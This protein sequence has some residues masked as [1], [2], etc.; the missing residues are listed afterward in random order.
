MK[1]I[2]KL[3]SILLLTLVILSMTFPAA[4]SKITT[5][6]KAEI[7]EAVKVVTSI[8]GNFYFE[9]PVRRSEA[10]TFIVRLIG[11]EQYVLSNKEK[12]SSVP[13]TD[14]SAAQ[15]FS[16]NIGYCI[17]TGYLEKA[18][19][20][21]R[22]LDFITEKEFLGLILLAMDYKEN[23]DFTTPASIYDLAR[24]LGLISLSDY[25]NNINSEVITNRESAVNILYNTLKA[26]C[27]SGEKMYTKLIK[28][29]VITTT[30]AIDLGL[31]TDSLATEIQQAECKDFN[32]VEIVF[33]E[34]AVSVSDIKIYSIDD[35]EY[36]PDCS[37]ISFSGNTL[38]VESP[39]LLEAG[40]YY[41]IE[42]AD[43][44]D[45]EGNITK[46]LTKE[47]EGYKSEARN[48]DFFRIS[49]IEPISKNS[50]KVYFTH[51]L[52]INNEVP[53]HYSITR[54]NI[55]IADGKLNELNIGLSNSDNNAVLITLNS[56][57]FAE[58]A[59]YCLN[60][61]G[62]MFS[63]YGV[64]LNDGHGDTMKFVANSEE[65]SVFALSEVIPVDSETIL[66]N[67]NKEVNKF[68]ANQ[69]FNF[70]VTDNNNNPIKINKTV[71]DGS[72]HVIFIKLDQT[73]IK[74]GT[75]YLTVNNL[76]DITRREYI[77]EKTY[78]FKAAYD[79]TGKFSIRNV[80]VIDNQTIEI[81][82]NKPLNPDQAQKLSNYT[83]VRLNSYA[84]L[85][86]EKVF[87]DAN[88][89]RY[90]VKLF[91]SN[92]LESKYQYEIRINTSMTDILD[93][94]LYDGIKKF[95]GT[96]K[97]R[98]NIAVQ[99]IVPVSKDAVKI[100]FSREIA[101]TAENLMPSNFVYGYLYN[102]TNIN[103]VPI[104]TVYIDAKTLILKFDK[105][106]YDT[107]YR[108][109]ISNI[110]D[111]TGTPVKVL[112]ASFKLAGE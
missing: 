28:E 53:L 92:K 5:Q 29:G 10:V 102:K 38:R 3:L 22:P 42:I 46:I 26:N 45:N 104:S 64:G 54:D 69:I 11:K 39:V 31:Y 25:I 95:Y 78:S 32:V 72:G 13:Y 14:V 47:F 60:I 43:V 56:G 109:M 23:V 80:N 33:N 37:T 87:Y 12:Y 70:Y 86:P 15:W 111:Y 110:A 57:E 51:P 36:L 83:I 75:Y 6:E 61:D 82:F 40:K 101:F 76:N 59:V 18:A 55:L 68:L 34:V 9:N 2:S 50:I 99:E 1:T 106:E 63:K 79:S 74:N 103:K 98:E 16:A 88:M 27:K 90:K 17:E 105:L 8:N 30:Q 100:T 62:D 66:L 107:D 52:T 58:G 112:E 67:F 108:L 21:F 93:N 89:D 24:E 73:M 97:A 77:T 96:N 7:L 19:T 71:V 65:I 4:A 91:L 20:K 48:S 94:R 49:E 85:S 44:I 81:S 41:R 84:N 35:E